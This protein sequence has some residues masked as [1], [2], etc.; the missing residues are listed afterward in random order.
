MGCTLLASS[1]VLGLAGSGKRGW[2]FMEAAGV[3][4]GVLAHLLSFASGYRQAG[5][6]RYIEFLLR[7]LPKVAPDDQFVAFTG[8][9]AESGICSFPG[10]L[11]WSRSRVPTQR[12]EVRILWE[13]A[14]APLAL[15]RQRIEVV[16]GPVNVAPVVSG[17]PSVV[18]VHD[19]AFLIYPEQYPGAKQRYLNWVTRQ[20]VRR[21]QRVIA[22]S[23]HTRQ[24]ILRFYGVEPARVV[25][26]PN[27]IDPA[28]RP[29]TDEAALASL[30]AA[31][32]LDRDFVLFVGTLQ[33]RKNLIGLL[34]A[35]AR[36]AE[37][38]EAP[39]VVVGGRGWLDDP[40]FHEARALGIAERV[41]FAG[42]ADPASLALWYSAATIFVY[43]SLYEGFGL[44]VLEAMACGAPVITSSTSSL[45]EV[46][47]EA[48]LLVDPTDAAALAVAMERALN[49]AGL[50]ARLRESGLRRARQFTWERTARETVA[51]YRDAV[52]NSPV[53]LA[54]RTGE[55]S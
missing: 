32:G 28:M 25:T 49:D 30:R 7:A 3:R 24:D 51:V 48:A 17:L 6:S 44:P 46:A 1:P 13:Q 14:V 55:R 54:A 26:V 39:L 50:R 22:V 40:V 27:G 9:A 47:G 11:E 36:I 29:V 34:R 35:Y 33:P 15:R 38:V 19:L 8:P 52:R 45:P 41:V 18:T 10:A 43:P 53:A 42:Y 5:V 4:V 16:H 12:P 2:R 20:S 21:A 31:H 23:E 37:R